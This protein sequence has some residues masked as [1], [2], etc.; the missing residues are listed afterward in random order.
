MS[1]RYQP[2]LDG[3]RAV[4]LGGVLLA[5]GL[6]GVLPGGFLGVDL[7]FVLSGYLITALLLAEHDAT[8][9]IRLG[10]RPRGR[11]AVAGPAAGPARR[12]VTD[13]R[14]A[15]FAPL[16][17]RSIAGR[18]PKVWPCNRYAVGWPRPTSP[19]PG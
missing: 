2:S 11:R 15:A 4:A 10:R 13:P 1:L 7:F 19:S 6:P 8:G 5:H 17:Q 18:V 16:A 12:H 3:L 14:R 9:R